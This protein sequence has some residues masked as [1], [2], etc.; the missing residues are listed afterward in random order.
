MGSTEKTAVDAS[1]LRSSKQGQELFAK[2]LYAE[3]STCFRKGELPW[4]ENVARVYADREAA[5]KL[6]SASARRPLLFGEIADAFCSA[7]V[8]APST[9]DAKDL[10]LQSAN[11]YVDISEND[12]AAA[13]FLRACQYTD[14]AWHY[15]L[16]GKL[17]DAMDIIAE[18]GVDMDEGV[19][20]AITYLAKVA[21]TKK[22]ETKKALSLF[23]GGTQDYVN[24]LHDHGFEKQSVVVLEE[25]TAYDQAAEVC[26][27][28]GSHAKAVDLLLRCKTKTAMRRAASFLL[29]A[30][31]KELP[32]GA[33]HKTQNIKVEELITFIKKIDLRTDERQEVELLHALHRGQPADLF[34]RNYKYPH[35]GKSIA[36]DLLAFDGFLR[37]KNPLIKDHA[38][39]ANL[40]CILQVFIDYG[41]RV[42]GI[43]RLHDILDEPALRPL[44]GISLLD[45]AA[46][47]HILPA[48]FIYEDVLSKLTIPQDSHEI[49]RNVMLPRY[50]VN[51][52]VRER[53]LARFNGMLSDLQNRLKALGSLQVC[54][55]FSSTGR[56]D[57]P[58]DGRLC[59]FWHSDTRHETVG[60]FNER[61]RVHLLVITALDNFTAIERRN[62]G[63]S[64]DPN[65]GA[66]ERRNFFQRYWLARLFQVRYPVALNTGNLTHIVPDVIP[67][68]NGLMTIVRQWIEEVLRAQSPRARSPHM[69]GDMLMASMLAAYFD[70]HN[71]RRY[72]HRSV[73]N[74]REFIF[75][76]Q[77]F[78]RSRAIAVGDSMVYLFRAHH[79]RNTAISHIRYVIEQKA[80][81][82][83][84]VLMGFI[85]DVCMQAVYIQSF[86]GEGPPGRILLPRSWMIRVLHRA[87]STRNNRA[88][89]DELITS[90]GK[91]L[92]ILSNGDGGQLHLN[93]QPFSKASYLRC[94]LHIV[95]LCQLMATLGYNLGDV[96]LQSNV[97]ECFK[98]L[99]PVVIASLRMSSPDLSRA[100]ETDIIERS[101]SLIRP[102]ILCKT[103]T[104][105]MRAF[106]PSMKLRGPDELILAHHQPIRATILPGVRCIRYTNTKD[107]LRQLTAGHPVFFLSTTS[108][109]NTTSPSE[110]TISVNIPDDLPSTILTDT[111]PERTDKAPLGKA[112]AD[113]HGYTEKESDAASR[114]QR[115]F[116]RYRKRIS[117]GKAGPTWDAF[118][119]RSMELRSRGIGYDQHFI[120][121]TYLRGPLPRVMTILSV[122]QD[123]CQRAKKR[124]DKAMRT[125]RS[126]V[127]E[128]N[129]LRRRSHIL[130]VMEEVASLTRAICPASALHE[131]GSVEKLTSEV[132]KVPEMCARVAKVVKE[133]GWTATDDYHLGVNAILISCTVIDKGTKAKAKK[134]KLNTEDLDILY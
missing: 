84:N 132:G 72:A 28:N 106:Q 12:R 124:V 29:D 79:Q 43:A 13:V 7:A 34:D 64:Q 113:D 112:D 8:E 122:L 130:D 107:L 59:G 133:D 97:L 98:T 118:H 63:E 119:Q 69:L 2:R 131:D 76:A 26:I 49:G 101:S 120:Y 51:D 94:N 54:L 66:E 42:R 70:Y 31:R 103:W 25:E 81:A 105:V 35:S 65:R 121:H 32:F 11:C 50:I 37:N 1:Y 14:S 92:V 36:W 126:D 39:M 41:R 24:F 116:V 62:A 60:A 95:R 67:D 27:A 53:L 86:P 80:A 15:R 57:R 87:D 18:H 30:L 46:L 73:T 102:F 127:V 93:G 85:E 123:A 100:S 33:A 52:L 71:A 99:K 61:V 117:G 6:P 134:P 90:L 111:D 9:D 68:F 75:I 128:D 4:L 44:F 10:Y 40:C 115:C 129:I 17:E 16:A 78:H 109:N 77:G 38:P 23:R 114:I 45:D 89:M 22:S 96:K 21:Y 56:C 19:K 110:H 58:V 20:D 74:L 125:S 82:D 91:L 47:A 55:K 88:M 3:A 104:E 83:V 5:R 48:S 108:W